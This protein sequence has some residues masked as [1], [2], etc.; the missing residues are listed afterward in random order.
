MR[1]NCQFS[2]KYVLPAFRSILTKQLITKHG[3]TQLQVASKLGLTQTAI[4]NYMNS[5]RATKGRIILGDDFLTIQSMACETAERVANN[6][7]TKEGMQKTLCKVCMELREKHV[8][9][10]VI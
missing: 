8:L 5:K 4:S 6:K 7:T 9:D 3:L 1:F 10:Y 2:V